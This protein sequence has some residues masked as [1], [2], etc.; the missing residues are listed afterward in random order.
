MSK[1]ITFTNLFSG[2]YRYAVRLYDE[3]L[4]PTEWS[5]LSGIIPVYTEDADGANS[6][7]TI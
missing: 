1:I 2:N 5:Y 7:N 4:V 6:A 3:A